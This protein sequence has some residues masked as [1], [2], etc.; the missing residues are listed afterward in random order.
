MKDSSTRLI[1]NL[2]RIKWDMTGNRFMYIQCFLSWIPGLPGIM[3]RRSVYK[4]WFKHLGS[5]TD[6]LPGVLIRNPQCLYV[7]KKCGLGVGVQIQAAGNVT[8]E[9]NVMLGPGV[10]IWSANHR[11]QDPYTPISE[12]GY[13]FKEVIIEED[14]WI[15]AGAFVMP[16]AHIG[17]GSVIAAQSVV[18]AKKY[19]QFSILAGN[20]ARVIGS[21][22]NTSPP[23]GNDQTR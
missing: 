7:G 20:P 2:K 15:G 11:Y 13:E 8:M 5:D 4:S 14:T 16:G 23:K 19:K 6:I 22:D 12:Q 10:R 3:I 9:D 18:G 21:R 17:R 1:H